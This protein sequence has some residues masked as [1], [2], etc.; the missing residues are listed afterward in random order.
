MKS[1]I[2][3]AFAYWESVH[4]GAPEDP[5]KVEEFDRRYDEIIVSTCYIEIK[6]NEQFILSIINEQA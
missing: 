6:Y 2:D 3:E 1:W 4:A 5:V